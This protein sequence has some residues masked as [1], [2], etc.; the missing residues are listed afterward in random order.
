MPSAIRTT[1]WL[2]HVPLDFLSRPLSFFIHMAN[3]VKITSVEGKSFDS[4]LGRFN[5]C[6]SSQNLLSWLGYRF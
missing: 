3:A 4:C 2:C 1:F 5:S 6:D